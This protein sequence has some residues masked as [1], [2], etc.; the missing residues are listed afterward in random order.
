MPKLIKVAVT[1]DVP[2]GQAI[3]FEAE[4]Q[5]IALFNVS[6]N[7]YAL[8]DTCPHAGG[9]LSEGRVEGDQVTCPLHGAS[10]NLRTG[11]VLTPPA[12]E[13][14]KTYKVVIEGDDINVEI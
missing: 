4:G 14:V 6:G 8:D 7:Y 3:V 2:P 1:S 13:D 12:F 11:E 9:P 5:R 10:F